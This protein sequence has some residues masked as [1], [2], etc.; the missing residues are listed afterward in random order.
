HSTSTAP[1]LLPEGELNS[2]G[3]VVELPCRMDSGEPSLPSFAIEPDSQVTIT[4][5]RRANPLR[6]AH[7]FHGYVRNND[8]KMKAFDA[9]A[10]TMELRLG[11][12]QTE[13][14]QGRH[15][16]F[17]AC[18]NQDYDVVVFHLGQRL[19]HVIL[20]FL[21]IVDQDSKHPLAVTVFN[22][23]RRVCLK[24]KHR[25]QVDE[26]PLPVQ[27]GNDASFVNSTNPFAFDHDVLSVLY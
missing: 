10:I 2:P 17:V 6:K 18:I 25:A 16:S 5:H 12:T 19:V 9:S 27:E 13:H 14:G 1:S 11:L 7:C 15:T 20:H 4:V 26:K 24:H 23:A 21:R 3:G 8:R 22:I